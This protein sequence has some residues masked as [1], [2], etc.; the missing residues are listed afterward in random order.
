MSIYFSFKMEP[1]KKLFR[2]PVL[3]YA[4]LS[5]A[6]KGY[7]I[8]GELKIEL[9]REGVRA[10]FCPEGILILDFHRGNNLVK[11]ECQTYLA[12][13]GFHAAA[14][15]F[16]ERFAKDQNLKISIEDE[17]GYAKNKNFE[18]MRKEHFYPWLKFMMSLACERDADSE[19]RM[20][21]DITEYT[22][23]VIPGTVVTPIRRFSMREMAEFFE[24]EP[25]VFAKEFFVW[26]N[27]DRDAL[28]YRNSALMVISNK[29][30]F[31]FSDRNLRD[32]LE[33]VQC[34]QLLEKALKLDFKLPFPKK[35]YKRI[36]RLHEQEAQNLE[37]VPEL[38]HE[39]ELGY[40]LQEIYHKSGQFTYSVP[41][42]CLARIDSK[43][44]ALFYYDE[45]PGRWHNIQITSLFAKSGTPHFD[46]SLFEGDA[47]EGV[48][49]FATGDGHAKLAI[50]R[51]VALEN[52]P[53]GFY[54]EM[55]AQ[56]I[57]DSQMLLVEQAYCRADE[58][59]DMIRWFKE[60]EGRRR[61][62]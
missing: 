52:S 10:E 59:K 32:G 35:E 33:N 50:R 47:I 25:E 27:Q 8:E 28:F 4:G 30:H 17:T 62:W 54:Y 45:D 58:R 15:D 56:M 5:T 29:C 6:A 38:R 49:E 36:C 34:I 19:F 51:P 41:G 23:K 57:L 46:S 26:N 21:W 42:R 7:A 37:G 55:V 16:L 44:N 24:Q 20:C 31:M 9:Q 60:F 14:I 12:G 39:C 53:E 11:G 22:P 40:R 2:K 3:D 18:K 48:M 61:N 43:T 1:K 13:P